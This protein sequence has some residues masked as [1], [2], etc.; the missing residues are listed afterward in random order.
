MFDTYEA[1]NENEAAELDGARRWVLALCQDPRMT[2]N[3]GGK[4]ALI[5][6]ILAKNLIAPDETAKLQALGIVFGDA[7]AQ[8]LPL[9]SWMMVT[10]RF[11][12]DAALVWGETDITLFPLTMISKRIE[13]GEQV[14]ALELFTATCAHLK[15]VVQNPNIPKRRPGLP[16]LP[17]VLTRFA[18]M[19]KR[20]R[21]KPENKVHL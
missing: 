14:D 9:L 6:A 13:R 1:L 17:G 20:E 11:G 21:V 2:E 15:E 5:D 4:L 19:L 10:G 18:R 3:P 12:R 16:P 7:L 8:Q